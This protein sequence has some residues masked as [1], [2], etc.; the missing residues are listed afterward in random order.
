MVAYVSRF[1]PYS[2]RSIESTLRQVDKGLEEA[3]SISG[4]NWV[5]TFC[6]ISLPLLK[7]GLVAGFILLYVTFIRELSCSILLY[8]SGSEVF[9]VAMF[10]MWRDGMFP[11]LAAFGALQLAITAATLALFS[12]IFRIRITEVIR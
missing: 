5:R 11:N 10:D 1:M 8:S 12:W 4:A 9:S 3:A 2:L 7:P 6:S